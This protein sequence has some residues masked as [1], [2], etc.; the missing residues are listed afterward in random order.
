MGIGGSKY[1]LKHYST[2]VDRSPPEQSKE[3]VRD[4]VRDQRLNPNQK[5]ILT[6]E[7]N[8]EVI[9]TNDDTV[10][11]RLSVRTAQMQDGTTK[12]IIT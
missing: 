4:I 5:I 8:S 2:P 1:L 9:L 7:D 10:P 6:N 3:T 12:L 11:I